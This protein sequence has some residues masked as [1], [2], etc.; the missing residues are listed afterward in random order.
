M[1]RL[2][3]LVLLIGLVCP[4]Q[5]FAW[6]W[7]DLWSTAD[8]QA[9]A[10]LQK[11][12]FKQA[13]EQFQQSDWHGVASY[14]AGDY[15]QAAKA[16]AGLDSELG[17]YNQ[18]NALAHMGQYEEGIAAYDKALSINPNNQDAIDNR[19]L[20]KQLL[21]EEKQSQQEQEQKQNQQ[22]SNQQQKQ[23]QQ[24]DQQ[25]KQPNQQ[26]QQEK[27]QQQSKSE[28]KDEAKDKQTA[29]QKQQE[30]AKQADEGQKNKEDKQDNQE[31]QQAK[32]QWL[33]LIPDDPGGLLREK[34]LRDHV[35]RQ[36]GW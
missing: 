35:R 29:E 1:K 27:Q 13:Q 36:H 9:Q 25:N 21:K 11:G 14:R 8:Q 22:Q 3:G 17:Y 18:G 7:R 26:D 15:Q 19:Q 4:M 30:Q 16:F 31:Q 23:N 28:Q 20:L 2:I 24:A 33:K 32:A 6:S 12:Q 34:F 5:L 10:A